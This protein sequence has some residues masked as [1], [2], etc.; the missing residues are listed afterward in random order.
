MV[1]FDALKIGSRREGDAE[2]EVGERVGGEDVVMCWEGN[3]EEAG[4]SSMKER[5]KRCRCRCAGGRDGGNGG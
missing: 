5:R 3:E 1:D 2:F 4:T